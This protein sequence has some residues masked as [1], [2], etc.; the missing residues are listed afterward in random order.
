MGTISSLTHY[1]TNLL[2]ILF[3]AATVHVSASAQRGTVTSPSSVD[4][5]LSTSFL[6]DLFGDRQAQVVGQTAN[7]YDVEYLYDKLYALREK[8]SAFISALERYSTALD[9]GAG[10]LE[11]DYRLND[12]GV[13]ASELNYALRAV[14][15]T[16]ENLGAKLSI[17]DPEIERSLGAYGAAKAKSLDEVLNDHSLAGVDSARVK[18]AI[19]KANQSTMLFDQSIDRL[20]MVILAKRQVSPVRLPPRAQ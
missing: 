1:A 5:Y 2:I 8:R 9:A 10:K 18:L 12:V 4:K 11:R 17:D 15:A 6:K 3:L 16:F 20:R 13:A 14:M 19:A 7:S